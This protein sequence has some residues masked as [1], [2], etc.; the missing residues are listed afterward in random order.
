MISIP[1]F[2]SLVTFI[3]SLFS[4]PSISQI[5]PLPYLSFLPSPLSLINV[6]EDTIYMF[7]LFSLS[8]VIF[9]PAFLQHFLWSLKKISRLKPFLKL[10]SVLFFSFPILS[11]S[12]LF[13]G[14]C[15]HLLFLT[16]SNNLL[17]VRFNPRQYTCNDSGTSF[18]FVMLCYVFPEMPCD[19]SSWWSR[20]LCLPSDAV[21]YISSVICL[22]CDAEW[23]VSLVV[24]CDMFSPW[25]QM[26]FFFFP[27]RGK[28]VLDYKGKSESLRCKQ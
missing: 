6:T 22:P 10:D 5:L 14:L 3:L 18:G 2:F 9:S 23:C 20:G 1:F 19:M 7:Y 11:V 8:S 21:R 17:A 12:L 4:L 15:L 26:F 24:T 28:A 27:H 25:C 16:P 13:L